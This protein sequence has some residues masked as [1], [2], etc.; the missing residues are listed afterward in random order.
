MTPTTSSQFEAAVGEAG[1]AGDAQEVAFGAL[2]ELPREV[3]APE[4][5]RGLVGGD[6]FHQF[7]RGEG[8]PGQALQLHV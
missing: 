2:Q 8:G 1:R 6:Y 3:D 4:R 7:V 5:L